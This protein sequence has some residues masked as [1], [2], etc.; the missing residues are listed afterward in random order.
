MMSKSEQL[1]EEKIYYYRFNVIEFDDVKKQLVL[2]VL[3][4][5]SVFDENGIKYV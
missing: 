2:M 5:R 1:K 3:T 4:T